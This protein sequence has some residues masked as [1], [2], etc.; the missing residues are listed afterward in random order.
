M[1]KLYIFVAIGIFVFFVIVQK[2]IEVSSDNLLNYTNDNNGFT[3]KYPI[4]W[5][6]Y[7]T[8]YACS[9][10]P[11]K[12]ILTIFPDRN[13][14]K[15]TVNKILLFID[16]FS[17]K[18]NNFIF[19]EYA[20]ERLNFYKDFG[21]IIQFDTNLKLAN[22]TAYTI[23]L[24]QIQ[25]PLERDHQANSSI[26]IGEIGSLVDSKVY[27]ITYIVEQTQKD[28]FLPFLKEI[29]NS[30][31]TNITDN[32][33]DNKI[34]SFGDSFKLKNGNNKYSINYNMSGLSNSLIA[35]K[36]LFGQGLLLKIYAPNDGS[37]LLEIPRKLLDSKLQN[38]T[39]YKFFISTDNKPNTP[40][41]EI[42]NN[43]NY[44]TLKIEINDDDRIIIIAGNKFDSGRTITINCMDIIFPPITI[45]EKKYEQKPL[46]T[47]NNSNGFRALFP[48]EVD[49]KNYTIETY[50]T[51]N[52]TNIKKIDFNSYAGVEL[53]R[54]SIHIDSPTSER[55]QISI[56]REL[57]DSTENGKDIPFD[58]SMNTFYNIT[59][60]EIKTNNQSRTLSIPITQ[61]TNV[62]TILG[63]KDKIAFE[64]AVAKKTTEEEEGEQQIVTEQPKEIKEVS[65]NVFLDTHIYTLFDQRVSVILYNSNGQFDSH[66]LNV[67]VTGGMTD[68]FNIDELNVPEGTVFTVCVTNEG[69]NKEDCQTVNREYGDYNIN[70]R[71]TVP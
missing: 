24:E 57:L 64:S 10:S 16:D 45:E 8:E 56:P 34:F 21:N 42:S 14:V 37:L 27:R 13:D 58:V 17:K 69:N 51:N 25:K 47:K 54:L 5:S 38:K 3:I 1:I 48:L 40:Y 71:M 65:L 31:K 61:E 66:Y 67:P 55:L 41:E 29:I 33:K 9:D 18:G 28:N 68:S 23:V 46:L 36:S 70:V 53:D 30:F 4:E 6:I 32:Q 35:I 19:N 2:S 15:N 60:D 11:T 52:K 12:S 22:K 20:F 44:R 39:D 43:S 26:L 50:S 59:P 49:G 63:N 62:I 7:D